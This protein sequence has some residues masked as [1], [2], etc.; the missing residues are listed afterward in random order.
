[1]IAENPLLKVSEFAELLNV[2]PAAVRRWLLLRK[3]SSTRIGRLV[4]IPKNEACRLIEIGS[5]PATK[6]RQ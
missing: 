2:T 6:S 5:R 4:R 1:M 3:I